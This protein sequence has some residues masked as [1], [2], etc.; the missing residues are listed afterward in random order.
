MSAPSNWLKRIQTLSIP[1]LLPV[2]SLPSST[3]PLQEWTSIIREDPLLTIHL[4]RYA[5]KLLASHDTSV[6]TLE[7][8]VNLLGSQ[9]LIV[10]TNKVA[11]I[12]TNNSSTKGLLNA[13]GDSLLAASLMRQWFEIR[14]IP[15]TESDYWMTLFYDLGLW[16]LWL[17]EP[18]LMEGIEHRTEQGE[19]RHIII[20]DLLGMPLQQWN[21]ELCQY[22]QLPV[23]ELPADQAQAEAR[24]LAF[25]N[26]ALKFF[27]PFSHEL[28]S[29]VRNGWDS[30]ELDS[31]CRT[32]EIS[33]GLPNFIN[34]LKR[35]V[36]IAAREYSLPQASLAARR[37]LA[38]Q[39]SVAFGAAYSG[40]STQDL[41]RQAALKAKLKG[42]IDSWPEAQQIKQ[43]RV[44]QPTDQ[45]TEPVVPRPEPTEQPAVRLNIASQREI[46][47]QFLNQKA[48]HSP[49]EIHESAMYGLIQGFGFSRIVVLER[50]E[51]FWQAFGSQGCD[52]AML[53]R[54]LK[55]SISSSEIL[56]Q[57]ARRTT[58][59]W[60]NDKNRAKA[61]R[62]LPSSLIAAN[63]STSFILRS[64]S[65]GKAVT[66]M[67]YVDAFECSEPLN[68]IDY[69]LFREYCAD[70]NTAL[71]RMR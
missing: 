1:A 36:A 41:Q 54:Q 33:L 40:F 11:R 61:E 71:N 47:R 63:E 24:T 55:M 30:Q 67:V 62:L 51:G 68:S 48:W 17:L 70:W 64:F 26:S 2:H 9:R 19:T 25:K 69:Q 39:P 13:I 28:A 10:L 4:F 44:K 8:A 59:V 56:S 22:F 21:K 7:H 23:F 6:K 34:H 3:A 65:I 35:W 57:L 58:A 18:E 37:L 27:L 60:V 46:R 31:L 38:T 52:K 66:M 5:N 49:V 43:Q 53:L 29:C 15:W 16:M 14:Q 45:S 32:G 12:E 42:T 50:T 20:A